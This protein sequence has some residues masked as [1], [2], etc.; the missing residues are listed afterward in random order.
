MLNLWCGNGNEIR[1]Y[2]KLDTETDGIKNN[3]VLM[4]DLNGIGENIM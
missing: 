1:L 3:M 2:K 4:D